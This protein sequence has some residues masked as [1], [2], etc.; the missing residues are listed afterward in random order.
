MSSP[1]NSS[2]PTYQADPRLD[3]ILLSIDAAK[4]K[5]PIL[6][7]HWE[8]ARRLQEEGV[9]LAFTQGVKRKVTLFHRLTKQIFKAQNLMLTDREL[10]APFW[11]LSELT[12][13]RALH[14]DHDEAWGQVNQSY[15]VMSN[16]RDR[17]FHLGLLELFIA[18]AKPP[19]A[20]RGNFYGM[21]HRATSL[22]LPEEVEWLAAN[23]PFPLN[24][25]NCIE[26]AGPRIFE[27]I[28]GTEPDLKAPM[29]GSEQ[30]LHDR[31]L[32]HE[33]ME[34]GRLYKNWFQANNRFT[35]MDQALYQADDEAVA[36][37]S[38]RRPRF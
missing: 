12:Q 3:P 14:C 21:L 28:L 26:A 27:Y 2:S 29:P 13:G 10:L 4:G 35:A 37:P 5:W 36:A 17:N 30:S 24:K 23:A 11:H 18:H 31:M 8:A 20:N 19:F 33:N 15:V 38:V 32:R 34:I 7:E 9:D 16:R 1:A 22:D 6:A 25:W